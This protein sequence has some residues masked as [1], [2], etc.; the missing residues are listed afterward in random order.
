MVIVEQSLN[1]AHRRPRYYGEGPSVSPP[2]SE[3]AEQAISAWPSSS[4]VRADDR[5]ARD[6]D[7]QQAL[8]IGIVTGLAPAFAA[9]SC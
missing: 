7:R 3:L 5:A 9:G 4:E 6:R 1:V 8:L 2:G